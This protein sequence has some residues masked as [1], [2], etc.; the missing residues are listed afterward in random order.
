MDA[1]EAVNTTNSSLHI[2]LSA[3]DDTKSTTGSKVTEIGGLWTFLIHPLYVPV[4]EITS[5]LESEFIENEL[6]PLGPWT[7]T[8]LL[9]NS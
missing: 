1:P 6:D 7:L 5:P 2:E 4:T 9:K 8:P 3:S